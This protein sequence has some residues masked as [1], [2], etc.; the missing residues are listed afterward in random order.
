M[1][2]SKRGLSKY[3]CIAATSCSN[4]VWGAASAS[5]MAMVQHYGPRLP[6]CA[7][8]APAASGVLPAVGRGPR[9]L[10]EPRLHGARQLIGEDLRLSR[11]QAVEREFGDEL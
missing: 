11:E 4:G 8:S 10:R 3:R 6:H 1:I 7:E 2:P 9:R 5:T